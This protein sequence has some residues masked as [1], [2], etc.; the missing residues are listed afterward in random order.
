MDLHDYERLNAPINGLFLTPISGNSYFYD[1][2]LKGEYKEWS[3]FI[4]RN[5]STRGFPLD[6]VTALPMENECILYSDRN[7]W[8]TRAE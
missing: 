3:P 6:I 2:I 1:G 5:V 4:L 8:S 7:R